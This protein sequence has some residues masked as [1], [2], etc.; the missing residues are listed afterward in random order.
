MPVELRE[1]TTGAAVFPSSDHFP[2]GQPYGRVDATP[3]PASPVRPFGLALAV[4]PQTCI[5]FDPDTLGYDTTQQIGLIRDG[6]DMV[7]LSK[8]TDGQTNT[9]TNADG[10]GGVDSD[11]DHRED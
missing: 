4:Q 10:H 5:S 9:Q 3:A 11:T 1:H 2:L 6:Q 7:P 8:H